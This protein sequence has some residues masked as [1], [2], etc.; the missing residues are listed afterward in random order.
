MPQGSSHSSEFLP[1]LTQ[2]SHGYENAFRSRASDLVALL[3]QDTGSS[4]FHDVIT[5]L[6]TPTNLGICVENFFQYAYKHMPIVHKPTFVVESVEL[7]LF[8]SIFVVGAI[9]SYP[10]DT[11]FMVLD[12][13]EL[14]ERCI[15]ESLLFMELCDPGK[16]SLDPRSPGILSLLQAATMMTSI[17]F[18]LPNARHRRRFRGQRF[19]DLVSAMRRLRAGVQSTTYRWIGHNFEWDK[20]IMSESY[21]R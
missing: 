11:Y 1:Q 9:W 5:N 21:S 10:R 20:Y 15:F 3:Q 17:G 14:A 7:P 8:L 4:S 2:G 16:G 13:V 6:L 12:I 19:T 18:A